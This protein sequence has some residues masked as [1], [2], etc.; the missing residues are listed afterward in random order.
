MQ[1]YVTNYRRKIVNVI[2]GMHGYVHKGDSKKQRK[3]Y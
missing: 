1:L 2:M 3:Q